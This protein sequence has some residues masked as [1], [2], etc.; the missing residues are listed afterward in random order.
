MNQIL[1]KLGYS[2]KADNIY[3]K[4]QFEF[5]LNSSDNKLK[6]SFLVSCS[7]MESGEIKIKQL[8]QLIKR[9]EKQTVYYLGY[10]GNL[11]ERLISNEGYQF[12]D[13]LFT[14]TFTHFEYIV[15]IEDE[16]IKYFFITMKLNILSNAGITSY[17]IMKQ[18]RNKSKTTTE[19][20][21]G[22]IRKEESAWDVRDFKLINLDTFLTSQNHGYNVCDCWIT[23]N[24]RYEYGNMPNYYHSGTFTRTDGL[25]IIDTI[26]RDDWFEIEIE[27]VNNSSTDTKIQKIDNSREFNQTLQDLL[28]KFSMGNI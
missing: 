10:V 15:D 27:I 19:S 25:I 3:Q 22:L 21:C 13:S 24:Q 23:H 18:K 7:K 20:I 28:V 26:I 11:Q 14:K 5:N 9:L 6:Y 17:E 4:N 12:N 8:S 2:Q 16:G 1:F